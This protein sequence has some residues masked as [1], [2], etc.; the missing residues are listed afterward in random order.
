MPGTEKMKMPTEMVSPLL[1]QKQGP[2]QG[3]SAPTGLPSWPKKDPMGIVPE[4]AGDS[5]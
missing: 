3:P 2:E 4:G 1:E 5:K